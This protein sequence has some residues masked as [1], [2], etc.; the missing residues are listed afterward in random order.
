[1]SKYNPDIHHRSSIRLKN[2]NYAETGLYFVTICIKNKECLFGEIF[3]EKMELSEMGKIA[4]K[5]W[6]K[7]AELR[8]NV[9][10]HE[11]VIMPNHFHA[12]IEITDNDVP[13]VGARRALPL[14]NGQTI[15]FIKI[16]IN[17]TRKIK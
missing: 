15:H 2:Y 7:T 11:F 16:T 3:E 4:C 9:H 12:I 1:M 17:K 6:L 8:K 10:L 5:E 13:P 14:P